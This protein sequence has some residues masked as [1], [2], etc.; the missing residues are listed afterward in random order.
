MRHVFVTGGSGFVGRNLIR[1]LRARGDTVHALARGDASVK[2]VSELGASAVRG[3][4]DD[5]AAMREGMRGCEVVFHAAAQVTE[6]GPRTLFEKVNVT[7]TRN[8]LNA[9]REAGAR[10]LVHVSTE[11]TLADGSP[12]V[13]VDEARALPMRPLPRYPATKAASER[14]VLQANSEELRT[15]AV[16]PRLIWGADDTSLLPQLV[17]AVKAGR[18]KWIGGGR[19]LTSTCHVANVVEGMLLAAE[20]GHGGNAYFLTD[21]E[22]VEFRGFLTRMLATQGVQIGDGSLPRGLAWTAAGACEA[23]WDTLRLPGNPPITRMVVN[24]FG[25]EVTV[26]DAKARRELSYRGLKTIDAGLAELAA[27]RA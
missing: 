7:G 25:Q 1:A 5:V 24:L 9:A 11:A 3:D 12:L 21:G 14:L 4:L 23:L 27:R 26:D 13:R 16:R 10:K 2:T 20:K 17:E 22:P 15:V 8:L 19:H 18:F 6:W